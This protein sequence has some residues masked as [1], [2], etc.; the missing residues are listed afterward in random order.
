ME[1][2]QSFLEDLR[3]QT[4]AEVVHVIAHSMGN[5]ALLQV[6]KVMSAEGSTQNKFKQIVLTAPDVPRIEVEGLL[7]A[8]SGLA[9]RVTLYASSKDK[10]LRSSKWVH[11]NPRLGYVYDVP[12]FFTGVDSIDASLVHTDFMGHS[13]FSSTRSVLGDLSE[14]LR[15]GASPANRFALQPLNTP[16]GI[17]WSFRP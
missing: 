17:C 2:F 9:D 7:N 5:R 11:T 3:D 1:R 16:S 10:A 4:G 14:L 12:Y 13:L 8:A 15:H 6:L